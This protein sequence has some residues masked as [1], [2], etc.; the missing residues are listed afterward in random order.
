MLTTSAMIIPMTEALARL[1]AAA[2]I[3]G[4]TGLGSRSRGR[5]V[6]GCRAGGADWSCVSLTPL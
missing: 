2:G 4:L 6:A 5:A 3:T 1:A